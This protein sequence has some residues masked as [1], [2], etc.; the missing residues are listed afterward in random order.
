M[1][2]ADLVLLTHSHDDHSD[3]WTLKYLEKTKPVFVIPEEI[4]P[5]LEGLDITEDTRIRKLL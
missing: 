1:K 4:T 3:P 5:M 2:K